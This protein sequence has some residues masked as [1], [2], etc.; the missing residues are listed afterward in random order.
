MARRATLLSPA[1]RVLAI[2]VVALLLIPSAG[3]LFVPVQTQSAAERRALAPPPA[4]PPRGLAGWLALPRQADAYVR[5]HV[6]FREAFIRQAM[7]LRRD[8]GLNAT[9][10]TPLVVAG[11][12][13]WLFL[14]QGLLNA[15]GGDVR[16]AEA[17]AYAA[18]VCDLSRTLRGR[19]V[20][21]LFTIAP[22]APAIYPEA[23]PD[24]A[25]LQAATQ[26]DLIFADARACGV[27]PVDLRPVL[28]ASK[29]QGLLYR[30]HDT[31][32]TPL[33][34]LLAYNQ[35]AP[36]LGRPDWILPPARL[37]WRRWIDGNSDLMRMSGRGDVSPDAVLDPVMGPYAV[38]PLST[39]PIPNIQDQATLASFVSVNGR[40]G[41]AVLVIGDSYSAYFMPRYFLPFVSRF[42]WIHQRGCGFDR[43]V[44][45]R[46]K[47][48]YVLLMPVDR[49]ASCA[50]RR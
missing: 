6:A 30:H 36:A 31:H 33:G 3:M 19:H 47:P 28:R 2:L 25:P 24:W 46:I 16:P 1:R 27:A 34:A 32:W 45:D 26:T 23:L 22:S 4:W 18:Y 7:R 29:G 14:N 41:P 15:T 49:E 12:N 11:K 20:P 43:R 35:L 44:F 50:K 5:D 9:A 10:A 13:D 38:R 17:R 21:L 40:P 42:G 37:T 39:A 48:D 8:A